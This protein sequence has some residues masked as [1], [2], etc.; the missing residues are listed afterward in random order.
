MKHKLKTV[1]KSLGLVL[2]VLL[3]IVYGVTARTD[4]S[5]KGWVY[6]LGIRNNSDAVRKFQAYNPLFVPIGSKTYKLYIADTDEKRT[7][8]LSDVESMSSFEGMAFIFPQAEMRGFWMKDMQFPLDFVY[9]ADGIVVD[10]IESV[11]PDTYPSTIQAKAPADTVIELNAGQIKENGIK[12]GD[13]L[14]LD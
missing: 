12:I 5:G 11:R 6:I 7:H 3:C 8:G 13:Q 10:L 4:G 14:K 1:F 2:L 9:V